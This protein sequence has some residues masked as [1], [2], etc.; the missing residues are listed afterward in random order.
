MKTI[1]L[2]LFVTLSAFAQNGPS[3]DFTTQEQQLLRGSFQAAFSCLLEKNGDLMAESR[4]FQKGNQ[5]VLVTSYRDQ[6]THIRKTY[7]VQSAQI[8]KTHAEEDTLKLPSGLTLNYSHT[9]SIKNGSWLD[10][11]KKGSEMICIQGPRE[12]GNK[13]TYMKGYDLLKK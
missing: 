11:Y 10:I 13:V 12:L 2:L 9:I 5:M 8:S 3:N 6:G 1:F 7:S 4:L